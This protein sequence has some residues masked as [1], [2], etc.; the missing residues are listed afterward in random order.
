MNRWLFGQI[1]EFAEGTPWLHGPAQAYANYGVVLFGVLLVAGWWV[2]RRSGQVTGVAAAIAAGGAT[3]LAVAVNQPI[4]HAVHEARPYTTLPNI[5]VLAN[6]S[7]DPSFPSDHATMA[8]AVAVGLW[9]VNRRLGIIAAAAAVLM[10]FTRVYI[11]AHFPADVVAGL[12]L[13]GIVALGAWLLL[14]RPLTWAVEAVATTR[15]RPVLVDVRRPRL[16]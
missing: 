6:R 14:R 7:T 13:G 15:L 16:P 11:A 8:G 1:N 12:L 4:V 9:I 2:A 5:L 10:A 3:L